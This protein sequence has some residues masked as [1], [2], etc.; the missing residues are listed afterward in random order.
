ML[1]KPFGDFKHYS[2]TS[3][4]ES[5]Q[6]ILDRILAVGMIFTG[7]TLDVV[8]VQPS[9][10]ERAIAFVG[11]AEENGGINAP[12]SSRISTQ[13]CCRHWHQSKYGQFYPL[14]ARDVFF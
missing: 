8:S 13:P 14:L 6:V 4:Y 5:V 12:E 2:Q 9:R 11:E 10:F 1:G 7:I 3:L